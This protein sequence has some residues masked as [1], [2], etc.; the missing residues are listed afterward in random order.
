MQKLHIHLNF[1]LPLITALI[2]GLMFFTVWGNGP[3]KLESAS[4][5]GTNRQLLINT[6]IVYP[7]GVTLDHPN[8]SLFLYFFLYIFHIFYSRKIYWL[9]T[10]L[11]FVE[12]CNYDGTQRKTIIRGSRVENMKTLTV[13]QNLF[14]FTTWKDSYQASV[15]TLNKLKPSN[16]SM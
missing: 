9:D 16:F 1:I 8:R 3:A 6:N 11:D 5:D 13:F 7:Q 15:T 12:R 4:L 14:Y 2:L 10:Y